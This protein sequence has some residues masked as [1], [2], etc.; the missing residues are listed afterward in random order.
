MV[1]WCNSLEKQMKLLL[2]QLVIEMPE[3]AFQLVRDYA[4]TTDIMMTNITCFDDTT[5]TPK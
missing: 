4:S 2:R 5:P 1:R 3:N